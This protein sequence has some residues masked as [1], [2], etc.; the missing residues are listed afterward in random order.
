MSVSVRWRGR[1]A[2]EI[3][4]GRGNIGEHGSNLGR[5]LDVHCT[6]DVARLG[7]E[8]A[9][10][11]HGTDQVIVHSEPRASRISTICDIMPSFGSGVRGWVA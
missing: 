4:R 5:A 11:V 1:R 6:H 3:R 10:Y 8:Y 9:V 7:G 2:R